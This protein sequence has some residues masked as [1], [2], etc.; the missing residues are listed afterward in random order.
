MTEPAKTADFR[1]LYAP[2]TAV[3]LTL[4]FVAALL[5]RAAIAWWLD[6]DGA[7][8][9]D[10]WG[11]IE[12]AR[13]LTGDPLKSGLPSLYAMPLGYPLAIAAV[14]LFG[15]GHVLAAQVV[16]LLAGAALVPLAGWATCALFPRIDGRSA[17][18]VLAIALLSGQ[19][20]TWSIA[21]VSDTLAAALCLAAIGA[22]AAADRSANEPSTARWMT[23]A[24]FALGAC[25]VTRWSYLGMAIPFAIWWLHGLLHGRLSVRAAAPAVVAFAAICAAQLWVLWGPHGAIAGVAGTNVAIVDVAIGA[26]WFADW[27]PLNLTKRAFDFNEGHREYRFVQ[28]V[29][30][31]LP[32]VHPSWIAPPIGLFAGWGAWRLWKTRQVAANRSAL[33]LCAGGFFAGWLLFGG[34]PQQLFRHGMQLWVPLLPLVGWGSSELA[35]KS[36]TQRRIR[37]VCVVIGLVIMGFWTVRAPQQLATHAHIHRDA[38]LAQVAAI[39]ADATVFSLGPTAELQQRTNLDVRELFETDVDSLKAAMTAAT[40]ANRPVYL[41]YDPAFAAQWQSGKMAET[42][43][44]LRQRDFTGQGPEYE[45]PTPAGSARNGLQLRLIVPKRE[46][47]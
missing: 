2:P 16:S 9:Q 24:G 32:G 37:D 5:V 39:S 26:P 18:V 22:A 6:F 42:L 14:S 44:W 13:E 40:R 12:R 10:P 35:A 3:E 41:L 31:L 15:W 4:W 1:G 23:A 19:H 30:W 36:P 34:M 46:G 27:S 25:C 33:V 45:G 28:G 17:R 47:P 20:V 29:Y 21:S 8:G 43:T 11:Y 38:A 7:Y